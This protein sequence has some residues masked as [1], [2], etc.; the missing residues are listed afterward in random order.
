MPQLYLCKLFD[1]KSF[2][3]FPGHVF[4]YG[5]I[6]PFNMLPYTHQGMMHRTIYTCMSYVFTP[7]I[8]FISVF[9]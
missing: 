9:I 5:F 7:D 3:L 4:I 1:W 8:F 6:V 2:P